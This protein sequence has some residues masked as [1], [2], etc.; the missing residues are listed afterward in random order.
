MEASRL[1]KRM[2]AC[3]QGGGRGN[4]L[5]PTTTPFPLFPLGSPLG[6]PLAMDDGERQGSVSGCQGVAQEFVRK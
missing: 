1:V 6:S 3:R 2:L 5:D 4:L